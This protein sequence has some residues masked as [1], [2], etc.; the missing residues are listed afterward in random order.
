MTMF[1][2][3]N[4]L[5][6]THD[7]E[8][9]TNNWLVWENLFNNRYRAL[10][11]MQGYGNIVP[12]SDSLKM[13]FRRLAQLNLFKDIGVKTKG[14]RYGMGLL[15]CALGDKNNV[16]AFPVQ[17][18]TDGHWRPSSL[19]YATWGLMH[20]YLFG[21]M[22]PF[23]KY[24]VSSM[25]EPSKNR[26]AS[27]DIARSNIAEPLVSAAI[28]ALYLGT[29]AHYSSKIGPR[30]FNL[31]LMQVSMQGSELNPDIYKHLLV[32]GFDDDGSSSV[33]AYLVAEVFR[34]E[35]ITISHALMGKLSSSEKKAVLQNALDYMT[36]EY[37]H[38]VQDS[39]LLA[40]YEILEH[41]ER[42]R[43]TASIGNLKL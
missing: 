7:Y 43:T 21:N 20:E 39:A 15:N 8:Y 3:H 11:N 13:F 18:D 24:L 1:E 22:A 27:V 36:S 38:V 4:E 5:T 9:I 16:I 29:M 10:M 30:F 32:T 14:L 23:S 40:K 35:Y 25:V 31:P 34:D 2:C 6:V 19:G 41:A 17:K 37:G 33:V 42:V 12:N 28:N 26:F